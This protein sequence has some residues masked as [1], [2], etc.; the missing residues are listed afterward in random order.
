MKVKE[1]EVL[2]EM[3][4][5]EL[6]GIINKGSFSRSELDT[7][8]KLLSSIEKTKII[9]EM[10]DSDEYSSRGYNSRGRGSYD[11]Y[12]E[13]DYRMGSNDS[14]ANRR[15][16]HYVRGHYSMATKEIRDRMED[17]MSNNDMSHEERQ[18]LSRAMDILDR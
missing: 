13:N 6:H 8:Q 17:V 16:A 7:I 5:Q 14:Y 18:T 4:C 10:D 12:G 1:Y 3:L 15:G 2:E 9:I 11:S